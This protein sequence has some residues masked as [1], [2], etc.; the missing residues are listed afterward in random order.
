LNYL[1]DLAD[2][3]RAA[4]PPAD[5]PHDDTR[6]LFRMYALLLLA[7]G[8]AVTKADVH[9][10][11][12]AWMA[13]RNADHESLLPFESLSDDTA[14]ADEPYVEA[15]HLVARTEAERMSRDSARPPGRRPVP[16]GGPD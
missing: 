8:T 4:V 12:V 5:L 15:I 11:W 1:D 7:K 13:G 9:N 14:S 10:A 16:D 6:E 2:R 3:I